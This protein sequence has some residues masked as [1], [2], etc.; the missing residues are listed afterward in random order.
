MEESLG[1]VIGV[2]KGKLGSVGS[3]E[4][5]FDLVKKIREGFLEKEV[6]SRKGFV[7]MRFKG[8]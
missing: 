2:R 3:L 1:R 8:L 7:R 5:F 4:E 6:F